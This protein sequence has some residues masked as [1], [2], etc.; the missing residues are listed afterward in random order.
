MPPAEQALCYTTCDVDIGAAAMNRYLRKCMYGSVALVLVGIGTLALP[1]RGHSMGTPPYD[2]DLRSGFSA[3]T[4]QSLTEAKCL[5]LTDSV[6]VVSRYRSL[7]TR[8]PIVGMNLTV[9]L[10]FPA[11]D[12]KGSRLIPVFF[13]RTTDSTGSSTLSIPLA[14]ALEEA[15]RLLREDR[16]Y[17]GVRRVRG[18]LTVS[19]STA[20]T[21]EKSVRYVPARGLSFRLCRAPST[22]V[23][24]AS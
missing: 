3:T 11:K 6:E 5:A 4:K 12:K 8:Q 17:R 19:F 16:G 22:T 14:Q 7:R 13:T 23:G 15:K 1:Q 21:L 18:P 20:D 10:S 9:T 2:A 24:A